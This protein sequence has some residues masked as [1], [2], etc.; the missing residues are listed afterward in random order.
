MCVGLAVVFVIGVVFPDHF[1]S[2]VR[3][4]MCSDQSASGICKCQEPASVLP[5]PLFPVLL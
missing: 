1:N 4:S 3:L 5:T 2:K